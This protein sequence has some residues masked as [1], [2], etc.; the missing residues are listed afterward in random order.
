MPKR[1]TLLQRVIFHIQR[2][3]TTGA[4]V[5]ESGSSVNRTTGEDREVDIILRTSVG[6]HEVIA[7]I[8]SVE[9]K[10]KGTVDGRRGSYRQGKASSRPKLV[11]ADR[12]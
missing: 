11:L 9:H 6:Q 1:S 4:E 8:E 2:Q 5:V 3:L 7:A 12:G 10:R